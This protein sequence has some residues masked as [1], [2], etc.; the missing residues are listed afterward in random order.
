M[1][2]LNNDSKNAVALLDGRHTPAPVAP[3]HGT[4]RSTTATEGFE[5]WQRSW[6]ATHSPIMPPPITAT[7][8]SDVVAWFKVSFLVSLLRSLYL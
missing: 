3:E 7:S 6:Y 5:A 8:T 4:W 2:L 1:F